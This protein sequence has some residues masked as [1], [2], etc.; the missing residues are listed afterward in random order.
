[1][2]LT[3]LRNTDNLAN[4]D[5]YCVYNMCLQKATPQGAQ[6]DAINSRDLDDETSHMARKL[7]E[8]VFSS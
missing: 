4:M 6:K 8:I 1:M 5:A 2:V 7:E 3:H